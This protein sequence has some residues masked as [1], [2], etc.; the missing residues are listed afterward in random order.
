MSSQ[1]KA[2]ALLRQQFKTGHKFLEG[3]MQGVT[4]DMAHWMPP[5][6]AQP[7]GATY[8]HVLI[9][10]DF[11][12]NGLLKGAAPLLASS[13]TGKVGVSELPPQAP[14]HRGRLGQR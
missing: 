10:E 13:W 11:L 5:S 6:K 7:L 12:I 14:G 8:A 4:P 1:N 9:S 3:T 2:A